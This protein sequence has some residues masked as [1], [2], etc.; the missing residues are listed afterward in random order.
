MTSR[1]TQV[2]GSTI[3]DASDVTTLKR[4]IGKFNTLQQYVL[5]KGYDP[6]TFGTVVG[7]RFKLDSIIAAQYC[8]NKTT[9]C[10][11]D[12]SGGFVFQPLNVPA[13]TQTYYIN[14]LSGNSYINTS[15]RPAEGVN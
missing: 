5:D 7:Q 2:F 8:S 9:G 11:T 1:Q 6:A 15:M 10:E 3:F 13:N 4:Q 12:I 14:N